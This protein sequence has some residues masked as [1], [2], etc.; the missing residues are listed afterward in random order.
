MVGVEHCILHHSDCLVH[1]AQLFAAHVQSAVVWGR[2]T[3]IVQPYQFVKVHVFENIE[4][5]VIWQRLQVYLFT[6]KA[7]VRL[8]QLSKLKGVR[9]HF[10]FLVGILFVF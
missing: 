4:F 6:V 7:V 8:C 5:D 3:H 10:H 1:W 9:E 2:E